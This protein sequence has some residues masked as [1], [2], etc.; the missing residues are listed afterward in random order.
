MGDFLPKKGVHQL[1][2]AQNTFFD[3]ESQIRRNCL[4]LTEFE[5]DVLGM[6]GNSGLRDENNARFVSSFSQEMALFFHK[7]AT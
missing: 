2:I 6:S 7:C 3:F 1:K 4:V 5:F